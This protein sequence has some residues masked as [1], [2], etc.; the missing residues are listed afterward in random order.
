[1]TQQMTGQ[2]TRFLPEQPHRV[3][4]GPTKFGGDW[5]GMFIR[6]DDCMRFAM[7]LEQALDAERRGVESLYKL[8]TV[9]ADYVGFLR[10]ADEHT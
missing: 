2:P 10:Q 8:D 6:G 5:T 1:M 3:E 4:T 7:V 9:I